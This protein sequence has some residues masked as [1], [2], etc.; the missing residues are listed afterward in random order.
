MT[1]A[2]MLNHKVLMP[3]VGAGMIAYHGAQSAFDENT[4]MMIGAAG[5]ILY[6]QIYMI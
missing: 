4:A 2:Q 3:I 5:A 1:Y 6:Y